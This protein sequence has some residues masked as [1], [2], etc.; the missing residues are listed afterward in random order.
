MRFELHLEE[1]EEITALGITKALCDFV[2]QT[3]DFNGVIRYKK[4]LF[5]EDIANILKVI[6]ESDKRWFD[7]IKEQ[8]N[9]R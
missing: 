6:C 1:N 8:Y 7:S 5:L 4:P 3:N 9:E 2:N